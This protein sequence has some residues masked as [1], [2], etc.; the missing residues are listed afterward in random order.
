V[1]EKYEIPEGYGIEVRAGGAPSQFLGAKYF[2]HVLPW[3]DGGLTNTI[4][5]F[6]QNGGILAWIDN[7]V[8]WEVFPSNSDRAKDMRTGATIV[9]AE[10]D[11]VEQR[12]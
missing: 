7:V 5:L 11:G 1:A 4:Y 10:V 8:S 12:R 6:G 3:P 9:P 2:S